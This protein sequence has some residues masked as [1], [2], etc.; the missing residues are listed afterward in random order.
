MGGN[1]IGEE[2]GLKIQGIAACVR[3]RVALAEKRAWGQL[4]QVH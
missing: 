2:E 3:E 4:V 1:I